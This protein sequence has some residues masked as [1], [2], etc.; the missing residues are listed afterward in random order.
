MRGAA[1]FRWAEFGKYKTVRRASRGKTVGPEV[2]LS[3]VAI[4][5]YW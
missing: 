2:N 4:E 5:R 3:A 1:A